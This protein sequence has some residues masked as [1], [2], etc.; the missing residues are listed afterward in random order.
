MAWKV[1]LAGLQATLP[2]SLLKSTWHKYLV[3]ISMSHLWQVRCP[4]TLTSKKSNFNSLQGATF[5]SFGSAMDERRRNN[6]FYCVTSVYG[7]CASFMENHKKKGPLWNL[8]N[9]A[10]V[11]FSFHPA[12]RWRALETMSIEDVK[13]ELISVLLRST[14]VLS[15]L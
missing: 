6:I 3:G 7:L 10:A 13:I 8:T 9:Q 2:P 11:L 14:H 5:G 1:G 15:Q 12:V 4:K